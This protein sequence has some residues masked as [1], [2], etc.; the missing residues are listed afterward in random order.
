[1]HIHTFRL[2]I[3]KVGATISKHARYIIFEFS[4]SAS[5]DWARFRR[6]LA[7]AA[8]A[9]PSLPSEHS[10]QQRTP[11]TAQTARRRFA[12]GTGTGQRAPLRFPRAW[13]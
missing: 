11:H 4:A 2:R 1:M 8:L 13:S 7:P 10:R 12:S 5:E 9:L 6:Q 3:L